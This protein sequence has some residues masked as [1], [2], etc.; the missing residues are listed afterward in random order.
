M[1]INILALFIV[2]LALNACTISVDTSPEKTVAVANSQTNE[3]VELKNELSELKQKSDQQVTKLEEELDKL[4]LD[5]FDDN[6]Q[7]SELTSEQSQFVR[8]LVVSSGKLHDDL[9]FRYV[10]LSK[11]Q[12]D[13]NGIIAFETENGSQGM[14]LADS[15]DDWVQ[16]FVPAFLEDC[17]GSYTSDPTRLYLEFVDVQIHYNLCL[18]DG[19]YPIFLHHVVFKPKDDTDGSLV[20]HEMIVVNADDDVTLNAFVKAYENVR[21]NSY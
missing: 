9:G 3:L 1:R 17:T 16:W 13:L 19:N 8:G 4:R 5:K 10:G 18:E 14:V 12:K 20:L 15:S 11:S 6:S 7:D 21:P 2:F